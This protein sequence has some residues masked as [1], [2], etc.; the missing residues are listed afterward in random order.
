MT[1][2]AILATTSP[3]VMSRMEALRVAVE[4]LAV[5][6]RLTAT[7]SDFCVFDGDYEQRIESARAILAAVE[8]ITPTIAEARATLNIH[9]PGRLYENPRRARLILDRL[10]RQAEDVAR[11]WPRP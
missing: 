9:A 7:S 5:H 11:R 2:D 3:L 4:A 8:H 6:L 10:M 1:D